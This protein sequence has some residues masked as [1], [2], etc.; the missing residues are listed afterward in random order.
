VT[1]GGVS[2]EA[3]GDLA[4]SVDFGTGLGDIA[5]T[6][7]DGYSF[8]AS[9]VPMGANSAS[10]TPEGTFGGGL[11][12]LNGEMLEGQFEGAFVADGADPVGGVIGGFSAYVGVDDWYASGVFAGSS[13]NPT[14]S[15]N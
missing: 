15:P 14:P 8:G 5:I 12:G 1:Q 3:R 11:Q 4:A 2:S 10:V 7:F 13:L 6:N 9:Q